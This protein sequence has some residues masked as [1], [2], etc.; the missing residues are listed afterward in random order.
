MFVDG[1]FYCGGGE[2]TR[3][4]RNLATNPAAVVHG[5]SGD[6]VVIVEGTANRIDDGTGNPGLVDRLNAAYREKYGSNTARP[7]SPSV[8]SACWRG[9]T[10]RT[11]RPDGR[12]RNRVS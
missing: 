10:T 9:T 6:E 7:S 2:R 12:S 5:E 8:P 3:W 1:T 4:V 11:T